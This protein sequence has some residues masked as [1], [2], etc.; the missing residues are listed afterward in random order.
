MHCRI[1]PPGRKRPLGKPSIGLEWPGS[2]SP[3]TLIH[4]L[5]AP[6]WEG[7]CHSRRKGTPA[8]AY[9]PTMLLTVGLPEGRAE[10]HTSMAAIFSYAFIYLPYFVILV[11]FFGK[12]RDKSLCSI[13]HISLKVTHLSKK[14][15]KLAKDTQL[16]W[17]HNTAP[18]TV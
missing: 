2:S 1:D 18:R 10:W 7:E 9:Q 5:G 17:N 11:W 15:L 16:T 3:A 14:L 4:C 6:Q 8:G 13:Y 12:S